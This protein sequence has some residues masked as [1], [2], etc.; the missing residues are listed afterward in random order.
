MKRTSST[1]NLRAKLGITQ[2]EL[3]FFAGTRRAMIARHESGEKNLN[4]DAAVKID[5]INMC[6]V[7]V[8]DD[9]THLHKTNAVAYEVEGV[10]KNRIR[11]ERSKCI[12]KLL[13][14]E[15][16]MATFDEE[17]D[18]LQL[19]L[20]RLARLDFTQLLGFTAQDIDWLGD[21]MLKMKLKLASYSDHV[22][23]ELEVELA[24][25][26]TAIAIYDATL[27]S[28]EANAADTNPCTVDANEAECKPAIPVDLDLLAVQVDQI[29]AGFNSAMKPVRRFC[30]MTTAKRS[31]AYVRKCRNSAP[32]NAVRATY[33][34][35][36]PRSRSG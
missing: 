36:I 31:I 30:A 3:S 27:A 32:R 24:V 16:R 11:Y 10:R 12:C 1:G 14:A 17:R 22:R 23:M 28:L 25:Q 5:L 13:L 2:N 7:G 18:A 33:L 9:K 29:E 20:N 8:F 21:V 4:I 34:Y 35:A 15:R 26:R 19:H 6:V